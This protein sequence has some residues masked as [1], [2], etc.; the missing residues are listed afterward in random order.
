VAGAFLTVAG[1]VGFVVIHLTLVVIMPR[2]LIAMLTGIRHTGRG[3]RN[4]TL[5]AC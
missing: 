2:A 3:K 1:I 5:G 4:A